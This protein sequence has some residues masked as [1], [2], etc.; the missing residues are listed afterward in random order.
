MLPANCEIAQTETTL[1]VE[2]EYDVQDLL[3]ALLRLYFKDI[4]P[5][6]WT[7]GYAGTSSSMDFLL[8]PEEIVIEVKKTRKG[9][10]AN[11]SWINCSLTL[12]VTKSIRS[13]R[14]WFA[15]SMIQTDRLAI[16]LPLFL[17][18]KNEAQPSTFVS[19]FNLKLTEVEAQEEGVE[20][21]GEH[22]AA[23]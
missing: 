13:A 12:L 8:H 7:P 21:D 15:L 17:T 1:D 18:W 14:L 11:E 16:P 6:E 9:L 10:R 4:R 2:D 3:H 20:P 23:F 19:L 5:E 22:Q